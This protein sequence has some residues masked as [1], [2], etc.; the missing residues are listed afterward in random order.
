MVL[1]RK[2][3][4]RS[5]VIHSIGEDREAASVPVGMARWGPASPAPLPLQHLVVRDEQESRH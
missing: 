5:I 3:F 2:S 4:E 1:A